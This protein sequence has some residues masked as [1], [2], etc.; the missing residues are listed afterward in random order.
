MNDFKSAII[1]GAG[2]AVGFMI[3]AT[4]TGMVIGKR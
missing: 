3:V 2:I 4:I 1:T